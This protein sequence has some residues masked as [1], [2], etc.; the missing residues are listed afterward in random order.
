MP[1]STFST[2]KRRCVLRR[3][4]LSPHGRRQMTMQRHALALTFIAAMNLCAVELRRTTGNAAPPPAA[5]VVR[6]L[7]GG[8][9]GTICAGS[10]VEP[11]YG[12]VSTGII[13]GSGAN[14]FEIF[15]SGTD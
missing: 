13:C 5:T 4:R 8:G 12:P 7:Q 14:A 2:R 3:V 1:D 6:D 15:D 11:P 9:G 10:S